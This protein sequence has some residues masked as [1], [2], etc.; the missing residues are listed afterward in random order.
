[1]DIVLEAKEMLVKSARMVMVLNFLLGSS[2]QSLQE[3]KLLV[4]AAAE[5]GAHQFIEMLFTTSARR[6]VFDSYKGSSPLPEVIA[7]NHG[8][9]KTAHY[10]EDITARYNIFHAHFS[11]YACVTDRIKH[12]SCLFTRL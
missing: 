2:I 10:L 8:H 5:V 3:L 12:H 6:K 7:R 11:Q 1:M 9:E 4:F